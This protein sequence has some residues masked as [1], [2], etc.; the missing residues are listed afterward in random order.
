MKIRTWLIGMPLALMLTGCQQQEP[1][2]SAAAEPAESERVSAVEQANRGDYLS[3]S[4]RARERTQ[5]KLDGLQQ[6]RLEQ[7]REEENFSKPG[8]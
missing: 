4:F 2:E 5:Q 8:R 6:E 1:E 3:T 7:V